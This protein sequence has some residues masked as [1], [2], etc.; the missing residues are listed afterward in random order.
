MNSLC[1]RSCS[2]NDAFPSPPPPSIC[3]CC[4]CGGGGGGEATSSVIRK[5]SFS[6]CFVCCDDEERAEQQK[7]GKKKLKKGKKRS[8]EERERENRRR[9][10]TT[11]SK[12][13]V[14]KFILSKVFVDDEISV[15]SLPFFSLQKITHNARLSLC[16]SATL[17]LLRALAKKQQHHRQRRREKKWDSGPFARALSLSLWCRRRKACSRFRSFFFFSANF[18]SLSLVCPPLYPTTNNYS[19]RKVDQRAGNKR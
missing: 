5:N 11:K 14:E 19:E 3:C 2:F 7:R 13:K 17:C 10:T 16:T 12:K 18:L 8:R 1:L 9:R 15:H 4:S 6:L